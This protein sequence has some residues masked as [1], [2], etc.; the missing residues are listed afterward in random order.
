MAALEHASEVAHDEATAYTGDEE[1]PLMSFTVL[2]AAYGVLTAGLGVAAL[3]RGATDV[4]ARDLALLGIATAKLSRVLAR[5]RVTSPLRAPFTRFED[6]SS[7]S[8]V[9]ESPRG[10]GL[11]LALGELL[12]CPT[13]LAQWVGTAFLGGLLLRPRET[14]LV[15]SLFA[16]LALNDAVQSAQAKLAAAQA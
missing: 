14:R 1:R 15:A 4:R 16:M 13:C 10:S 11:R 5:D 3:R 2:M 8:E 7:G 9:D 6:F 12:T